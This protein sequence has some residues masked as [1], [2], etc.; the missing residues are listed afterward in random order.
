MAK[1][2]GTHLK[3]VYE[4][5]YPKPHRGY[6]VIHD[7]SFE[8]ATKLY[9]LMKDAGLNRLTYWWPYEE[10]KKVDSAAGFAIIVHGFPNP[11]KPVMVSE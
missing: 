4:G 2:E 3:D 1:G 5:D 8:E 10:M 7:I 11:K 6:V 9:K